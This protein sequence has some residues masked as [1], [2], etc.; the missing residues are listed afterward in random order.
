MNGSP[1]LAEN[2]GP[3]D[4]IFSMINSMSNYKIVL[5]LT[6]CLV[7][8]FFSFPGN[9]RKTGTASEGLL[10][11]LIEIFSVPRSFGRGTKGVTLC[12]CLWVC[13]SVSRKIF[14]LI[15]LINQLIN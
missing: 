11:L 1:D 7:G 10:L 8:L 12:V 5:C 15:K 2:V 3:T 6:A 9:G 4:K 14:S 13:G